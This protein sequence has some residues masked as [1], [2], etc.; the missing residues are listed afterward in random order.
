MSDSKLGVLIWVFIFHQE[1][2]KCN[3]YTCT[4]VLLSLVDIPVYTGYLKT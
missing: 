4:S 2:F 1:D 3:I